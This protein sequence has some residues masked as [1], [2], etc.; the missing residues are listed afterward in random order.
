MFLWR[1]QVSLILCIPCIF[2]GICAFE[3]AVTASSICKERPLP[4]KGG[5]LE[6]VV[7]LGLMVQGVKH[8]GA[9]QCWFQSGGMIY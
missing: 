8:V 2:C 4:V 3:E 9:W 5:T 7:T 6:C 1:S